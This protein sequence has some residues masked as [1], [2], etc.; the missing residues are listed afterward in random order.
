MIGV[1]AGVAPL[2]DI[3]PSCAV[4]TPL[5]QHHH[6]AAIHEP[7]R[8]PVED[9]HRHGFARKGIAAVIDHHQWSPCWSSRS[10][11]N[12]L[13]G[14]EDSGAQRHLRI[15]TRDQPK[16]FAHPR[17]LRA[18]GT[19]ALNFAASG[20]LPTIPMRNDEEA[21]RRQQQNAA[22]LERPPRGANVMFHPPKPQV[23]GGIPRCA[24]ESNSLRTHQTTI[25]RKCE[26]ELAYAVQET[27]GRARPPWPSE[28][29]PLQDV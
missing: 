11:G 1:G 27:A 12:R 7:A 6:I 15:S 5:R 21:K 14:T 24:R 18:V 23:P 26:P 22:K 20:S 29:S 17:P 19:V 16:L 2:G 10:F 3:A 4:A 28:H 9:R 25:F 13:H 8:Q